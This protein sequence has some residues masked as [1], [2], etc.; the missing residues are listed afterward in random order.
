MTAAS[1]FVGAV[2]DGVGVAERAGMPR[3]RAPSI[4]ARR[5]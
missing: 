5:R 4:G 2:I 3:H 1:M